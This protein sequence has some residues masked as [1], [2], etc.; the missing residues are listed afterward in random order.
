MVFKRL[1]SQ[2][3]HNLFN[4]YLFLFSKHRE[5]CKTGGLYSFTQSKIFLDRDLDHNLDGD[6]E[7]IPVYIVRHHTVVHRSIIA[8]SQSIKYLD[9]NYSDRDPNCLFGISCSSL[10][11]PV[12]FFNKMPSI[13]YI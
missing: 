6:P 13:K 1:G 12:C 5:Y 7:R 3:F 2:Y 10:Q 11:L 9:Q 8:T 4:Q